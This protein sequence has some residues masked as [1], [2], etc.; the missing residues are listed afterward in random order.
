MKKLIIAVCAIAFAVISQAANLDWG[1]YGALNDG[2]ADT[3]WYSGGQAYLIYV[4]NADTFAVGVDGGAL[5]ITGGSIVQSVDVVDG[6]AASFIDGGNIG[7]GLAD[8][9]TYKFAVLFTTEGVSGTDLPAS[10]LYGLNDNDGSLYSVTWNKDTGGSF[11]N[12]DY[13]AAVTEPIPEPTSGL[14]LLLG[15]AGLALR[16]KQK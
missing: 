3:D 14:M 6:E 8:G 7:G 13:Y 16:R 10:G 15:V 2:A 12:V 4:T 9:T 1:A 5:S 11:A